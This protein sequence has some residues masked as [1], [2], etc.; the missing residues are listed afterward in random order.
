MD[1]IV[2]LTGKVRSYAEKW[3]A[4]RAAE[5]VAGVRAIANELEIELVDKHDD[6]HIAR[7]AVEAL[8]LNL[9]VPADRVKVEVDHGWVTLRG[10]VDHDYQRRAAERSVRNIAGVR[11]IT[12]LIVVKPKVEPKNVKDEIEKAFRR[13]AVLDAAG[14]QVEVSGSEVVLR[15]KVHSYT[16]REE[17]EKAAW[18][19]PGVTKVTNLL[20]V[21]IAA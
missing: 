8:S 6:T 15:G 4:E 2:T 11:G 7:E 17:A 3:N 14:I 18:A 19:A 12:N 21:E 10:D 9:L 13:H 1:G 20:T 16:E 5:R